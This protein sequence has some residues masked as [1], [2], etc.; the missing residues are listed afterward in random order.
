MK[1]PGDLEKWTGNVMYPDKESAVWDV[2]SKLQHIL[3]SVIG[4]TVIR[5]CQKY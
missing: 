3:Y 2:N 5:Q 4:G 1:L